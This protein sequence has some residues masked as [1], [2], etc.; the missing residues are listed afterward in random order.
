MTFSKMRV[1]ALAL[2]AFLSYAVAQDTPPAKKPPSQAEYDLIQKVSKEADPNARLAL[3]DQWAK[4]FPNSDYAD[5]R[6]TAYLITYQQLKRPRDAFNMASEILK[7]D[8]NNVLALTTIVSYIYALQPPTAADLDT[9]EKTC[10]YILSNLDTIYAPDKKPANQ[11]A[12]QWAQT[13]AAIK[14]Y[15]QRTIGWIYLTRKDYPRAEK[16]L[17]TALQSDPTQ[18]TA[19]QL[20]AQ[21]VLA[22]N[23]TNPE[24]QP[25]ALFEYARAAAYDGPGSLDA[26]SRNQIKTFLTKA[27]TQYHGSAAGLDQ[28]LAEAKTNALPPADFKIASTADIEAAKIEADEEAAK[29]NPMLAE[30]R[31]IK[32]GLTGDRAD[33]FWA[34]LKD[35]AVPG[36]VPGVTKFKGTLI[37]MTPATRP[38]ELVLAVENPTVPD[39][40]LKFDEPLPGK[41]EPGAQL[42]FSGVAKEY[43]KDPYMLTLSVD[44]ADLSG[45]AGRNAPARR[46]AAKK[47]TQ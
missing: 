14:P 31:T 46:P 27:Y 9:A 6:R 30:W 36:D 20:L 12:E 40:T 18:A 34:N 24:K 47:A 22:Q 2:V 17:E 29:A 13:K 39:V 45:W 38:K 5:T 43:R 44:K 28:L 19:S 21:A 35:A 3:E 1:V 15:A 10:N 37:S 41:M 8:P 33:A 32:T 23:K 26:A 4:D 16:E 7:T 11:T 42:E 25:L